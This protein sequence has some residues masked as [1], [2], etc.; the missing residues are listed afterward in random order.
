M[1]TRASSLSGGEAEASSSRVKKR[2][3][4]HPTPRQWLLRMSGSV[5][6]EVKDTVM[7][8]LLVEREVVEISS[9][10]KMEGVETERERKL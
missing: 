7:R 4:V 6:E 3:I 2:P 10:S 5:E 8:D 1:A 9:G